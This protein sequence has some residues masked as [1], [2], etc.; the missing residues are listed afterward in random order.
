LQ[1]TRSSSPP[2][3]PA[4]SRPARLIAASLAVSVL[5]IVG[6]VT[7]IVVS[8][9]SDEKP[10]PGLEDVAERTP[11]KSARSRPTSS[12]RPST[13]SAVPNLR[14]QV[15]VASSGLDGDRAAAGS[16]DDDAA[17]ERG[18]AADDL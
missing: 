15:R 5:L 16:Y 4:A 14:T 18:P 6:G 3:Q 2:D 7:A 17:V 9:S 8:R 12:S 1:S 10:A 11:R 13:L